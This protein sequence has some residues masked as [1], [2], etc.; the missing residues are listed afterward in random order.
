VLQE[1]RSAGLPEWGGVAAG[2]SSGR[3]RYRHFPPL[4]YIE[5]APIKFDPLYGA[6]KKQ[7]AELAAAGGDD[8]ALAFT[9]EEGV[10]LD[11]LIE[12]LKQESRY[13]ATEIDEEQANVVRRKLMQWPLGAA[14]PVTDLLRKMATHVHSQET[15]L[16]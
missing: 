2:G 13:H 3:D 12:T 8:A 16:G 5:V 6:I 11:G 14:P 15:V 4:G 1:R 10:R 9:E 7:N